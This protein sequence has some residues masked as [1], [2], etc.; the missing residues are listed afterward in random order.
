MEKDRIELLK[1][2]KNTL[3]QYRERELRMGLRMASNDTYRGFSYEGPIEDVL[4]LGNELHIKI[5]YY[6]Y[7]VSSEQ[8]EI[9]FKIL[10]YIKSIY[11]SPNEYQ[12]QDI[13]HHEREFL[14][15]GDIL[16]IIVG[17]NGLGYRHFVIRD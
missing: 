2:I 15:Q 11:D 12:L 6:D 17:Q 10:G 14:K 16:E 3:E 1:E 9:T 4:D 5:S 7:A 8:K 13:K